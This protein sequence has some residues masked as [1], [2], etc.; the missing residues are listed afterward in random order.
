MG[1]CYAV[2]NIKPSDGCLACT[3]DTGQGHWGQNTGEKQKKI[4]IKNALS[5]MS[6]MV[7]V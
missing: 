5:K 3:P 2:G 6:L 4:V 7:A 1:V